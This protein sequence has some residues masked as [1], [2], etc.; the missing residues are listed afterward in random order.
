[1][2]EM[3]KLSL[4]NKVLSDVRELKQV[5]VANNVGVLTG[6]TVHFLGD[7]KPTLIKIDTTYALDGSACILYE[8]EEI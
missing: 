6:L 2:D 3:T 4:I 7:E 5:L 1:M 8:K